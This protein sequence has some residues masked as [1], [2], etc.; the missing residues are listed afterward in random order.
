MLSRTM[1]SRPRIDFS[2]PSRQ[3]IRSV[4]IAICVWALAGAI[5]WLCLLFLLSLAY[6]ALT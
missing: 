6:A 1:I 2:D 5:I 3:V 4:R